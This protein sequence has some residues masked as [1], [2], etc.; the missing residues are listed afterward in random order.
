VNKKLHTA[1]YIIADLLSSATAWTLFYI[2]RK[3]Y[4]EP[5]RFGYKIPV[6][7]SQNFYIA[8]VTIPL[9]WLLFYFIVGY[10]K[11]IY[12][13][14]RLKELGST[15][16][17]TLIGGVLI[18]FFLILDD[19]VVSYKNYYLSFYVL[20]GLHFTLTYIPRLIITTRTTHKIQNRKIGFNTIMLGSNK[21]AV[22]VYKELTGKEKSA[23]NIFVGFIPVREK[24]SY[25]LDKHLENLGNL[26]E[27]QK[28]IKK[29]KVE[30]VILAIESSEHNKIG[31][32]INYLEG[33]NVVVKVIPD[34]YDIL[35]GKVKMASLYGV[36]LIQISHD[37]MP[38][39]EENVKRIIDVAI[40][41]IAITILM[42]VFIFLS[43]GV[44]L[45]SKGPIFYSH[46]RIGRYGKPF[47][48]YKFRSMVTDAEKAGPALSSKNDSRIT[49]FGRFM[50]KSRLDEIPQFYNVIIG[51]MSL[52][53]PRPE[54]QFFID[55]IVERAPHY[56][57]LQKVRPG[58]TSWG[59]VKFGYAENVDEMIERL[60]YDII[61]IES[62][63]L[64]TDFKILIYT[65][66]T[67][68]K[69]QGK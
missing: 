59:Q 51:D 31:K 30:E 12:R 15:A 11:N 19:W 66:M 35:T 7:F 65:I 55:Q 25:L 68:L 53:G 20:I 50:R 29:Y 16:L 62:M 23:G 63:S 5:Q 64:Y 44:K 17:I 39:W 34:M 26:D 24:D 52:V 54:R 56:I 45:S 67:V 36:A 69:A 40:S 18:F 14:S 13:K 32:I 3:L 57:H 37:L 10:Y 33:F 48:I 41:A 46:V 1:K 9:F 61:Y 22:A 60:K 27:L 49:S 2:F 42:P 38:A 6:E 58:I 43:L 8:L 28:I 4:V 21:K 47:T